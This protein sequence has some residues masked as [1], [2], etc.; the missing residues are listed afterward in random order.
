M[1]TIA[2]SVAA[3][4]AYLP[5][6]PAASGAIAAAVIRAVVD[7]GPTDSCGDEPNNVY[8]T[9]EPMI[10]HR[11]ATAGNPASSAYAITCGIR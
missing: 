2:A 11:P 8:T 6:S 1:P 7:S 10:A 3:S 4:P 9:I 5:G